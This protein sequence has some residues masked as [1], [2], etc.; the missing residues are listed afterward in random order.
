MIVMRVLL[1]TG[2]GGVGKTSVAAAT[3]LKAAAH[4][5]KTIV[6]STD[7]AHSLADSFD[8]TLSGQ[9]QLLADNLWGLELDMAQTLSSHWGAIQNWLTAL[10]AWRGM[11]NMV[12]QEM[13]VLPGM[14]EMANLLQILDYAEKEEYQTIVVD[15]APTGETLRLLS[16]PEVLRWWM[17]KLFPLERKAAKVIRPVF[18]TVFNVP[19]PED[20]VFQAMEDL[21]HKMER[22]H[23][24]LIDPDITSVRLVV[25][26]E[27][28]VIKE[29]QR[30]YTYLSLYGYATDMIVCNRLFPPEVEG[31]Y[32]DVWKRTQDKH[33]K[34][35]EEAFAPLPIRTIP[36]F[37][38]EVVGR[39]MLKLMGETLYGEEDPVKLFFRGQ[40]QVIT[41]E[42]GGYSLSLMLPFT[43]KEKVNLFQGGDEVIVE[44]GSY[45]RNIILPRSLA[46]YRVKEAHWEDGRLKLDLVTEEV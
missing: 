41:K 14:E 45:R 4:G 40:P 35:I 27:K 20:Q 25:N 11:Q 18:R 46:G 38:Q 28:M 21:F 15:C 37:S 13:A 3:A 36:L 10:F 22:L 5:H 44:V 26:A 43:S 24:L 31:G 16:F 30:T 8:I 6:L 34:S 7:A 33:F 39:D 9:A 1:F 32:F 42:N 19:Y 17:D 23:Q 12:A 29:A 2:K